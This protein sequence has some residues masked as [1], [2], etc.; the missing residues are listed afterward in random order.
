MSQAL[1]IMAV[2]TAWL[3]VACCIC[4]VPSTPGAGFIDP[5]YDGRQLVE[6]QQHRKVASCVLR[7][8]SVVALR[9]HH[10]FSSRNFMPVEVFT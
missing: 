5:S 3:L 2:Q 4:V 6:S 9:L 10:A 8:C 1:A 7:V